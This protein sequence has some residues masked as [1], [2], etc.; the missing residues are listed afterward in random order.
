[1]WIVQALLLGSA[2]SMDAFA[3]TIANGFAYSAT[4]HKKLFLAPIAFA[5][6]Q[7]VMPVIGF[8]LGNVARSFVLEYNGII[9]LV[10]LGFI[11]AKMIYDGIQDLRK[12]DKDDNLL[13]K[14]GKQ[15]SIK[16][17]ALQ[18][19]ATSIDALAVGFAFSASE[20]PLIGLAICIA[21]TTLAFC[22]VAWLIGIR[23]GH[24]LGARAQIFGGIIL[25]AIGIKSMFF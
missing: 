4:S 12:G 3:V 11:G 20:M 17:I 18:A 21:L 7:G 9:T 8:L 6:F 24:R 14:P 16:T 22:T 2:L 19:I 10:I 23:F 1:M 13:W 15:L 5:I 25:V